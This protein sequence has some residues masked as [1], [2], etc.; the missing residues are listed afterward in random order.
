MSLTSNKYTQQPPKSGASTKTVLAERV[1]FAAADT[2]Y[3]DPT[4]R[5]DGGDPAGWSD[6]GIIA[7]S[8]VNLTYNKE[9]KYV[10]TGIEKVARG[11]YS[12]SKSVMAE[13]TLDQYDIDTIADVAGLSITAVGVIGGKLQVGTDDVVEKAL[14]FI[15]VNKVD[16]K[17]HHIYSK[18]ASLTWA[19]DQ[20][21]DARVIKVTA[22]LYAFIPSGGSVDTL[23]TLYVLD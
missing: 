17:E 8:R 10:E 1:Y 13:F 7:D 16:G 4:A 23:F 19:A 11:A 22:R 18:K 3:A 5:L 21:D 14:L 2:A 6:L 12:L 15:G 9:I 20:Q